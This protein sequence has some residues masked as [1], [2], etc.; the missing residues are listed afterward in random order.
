MLLLIIEHQP[1]GVNMLKQVVKGSLYSKGLTQDDLA[2]EMNMSKQ[3]LS[4]LLTGNM[5][6][7]NALRLSDALNTLTSTQLTL[8][9][10]RKDQP[11]C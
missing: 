10:F 4:A 3:S 2:K 5:T 11:S 6:M 8:N 9:D 7:K 1:K